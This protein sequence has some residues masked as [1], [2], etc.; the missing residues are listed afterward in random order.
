ME[1][2]L[3]LAKEAVVEKKAYDA[4]VM[5]LRGISG[6][7]D[8]FLVCSGQNPVQV[9]A[10]ADNVIERMQEAGYPLPAREGYQGGRWILLDYGE[11]IVHVMQQS[12]REF[13]SLENLWHDAKV[14]SI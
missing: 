1:P 2:K 5:D 8:Y 6:V 12:E 3:T 13:Y 11:L 14:L 7:T 9:R 10:I 4:I